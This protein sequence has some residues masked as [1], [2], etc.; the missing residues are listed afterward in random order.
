[1]MMMIFIMVM[2]VMM[3]M[4]TMMIVRVEQRPGRT[5]HVLC[6]YVCVGRHVC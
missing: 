3:M 4:M 2:M 6:M 5:E 1:M